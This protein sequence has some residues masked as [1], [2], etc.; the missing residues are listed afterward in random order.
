[1]L[2]LANK[3]VVSLHSKASSASELTDEILYGM[4]VKILSTDI[5]AEAADIHNAP[6]PSG[7]CLVR[8]PYQYQ[9]YCRLE[10]LLTEEKACRGYFENA[11]L[12]IVTRSFA[13]ILSEPRVQGIC[14]Q[15][16]PRGGLILIGNTVPERAG[17]VEAILSD[18]RVGYTKESFLGTYH[19]APF[20]EDE[21]LFRR[22]L[23]ET[24]KAYLG[25]QYRWGGKSPLG[26]DCSGLTSMCYMLCGVLTYRDA[27]IVPGFPVKEIPFDKRK[28]GDLLYFPG[29]IA[30]YIG[31]DSCG[32]QDMYIHSTGKSGSDGVVINSLDPKHPLYRED[33]V[34]SLNGVG[35]IFTQ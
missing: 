14:L 24:A 8:T 11:S 28:P 23:I 18:G 30:M 15:T 10:D 3:S 32:G 21:G 9:G 12:K 27:E 6:A 34:K 5:P 31:D 4:S 7:W 25:T 13:D 17:W 16:I 2:A 29:H 19:T 26:I 1:M 33:L 22:T 20:T 35:S